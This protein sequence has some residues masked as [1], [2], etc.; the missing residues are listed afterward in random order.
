MTRI[1]KGLRPPLKMASL[2]LLWNFQIV[3]FCF[4]AS[5][6][7]DAKKATHLISN[8]DIAYVVELD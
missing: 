2:A 5:R 7:R 3:G 1:K 8:P 4:V 6:L